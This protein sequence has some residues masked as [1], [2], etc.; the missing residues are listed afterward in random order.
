MIL[1]NV[2]VNIEPAI[3]KEWIRWMKEEH[4]PEVLKTGCFSSHR[5]LR[6]L[7]ES[8]EAEGIT[9]AIQ[10][11]APGITSL[12]RYLEAFAPDIQRKHAERYANKF[13]AFR[14]FLEEV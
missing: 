8:P 6:L 4:I 9:F 5:F 7:N 12:N 11:M 2:T 13:V 10:Y 14:T 3:E 1:Y